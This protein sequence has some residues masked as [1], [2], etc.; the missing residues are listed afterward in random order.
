MNWLL[1]MSATI[2]AIAIIDG[3]LFLAILRRLDAQSL[4]MDAQSRRL[5]A[6]AKWLTAHSEHLD[7]IY[8]AH[9]VDESICVT[10]KAPEA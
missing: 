5:D 7:I 9:G 4:R 8:K 10:E 3:P 2:I 6:Q 1:A